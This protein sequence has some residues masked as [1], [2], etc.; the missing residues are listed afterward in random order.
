MSLFSGCCHLG[1]NF[2]P[3]FLFTPV[4][5]EHLCGISLCSWKSE[6][7]ITSLSLLGLAMW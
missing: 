4:Y 7:V 2:L 1:A 6:L 3:E 5:F